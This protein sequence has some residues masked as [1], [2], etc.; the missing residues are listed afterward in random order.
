MYD[1]AD[2]L[3]DKG[4]RIYAGLAN[5]ATGSNSALISSGGDSIFVKENYA[6]FTLDK[7]GDNVATNKLTKLYEDIWYNVKVEYIISDDGASATYNIYVNDVLESTVIDATP[8]TTIAGWLMQPSRQAEETVYF[9][10]DNFYMGKVCSEHNYEDVEISGTAFKCFNENNVAVFYTKQCANCGNFGTE[11]VE[12]AGVTLGQGTYYSDATKNG[13]REDYENITVGTSFGQVLNGTNA[14]NIVNFYSIVEGAENKTL[15]L[16]ASGWSTAAVRPKDATRIAFA[17]GDKLVM[18]FDLRIDES[19]HPSFPKD[20]I[21]AKLNFANTYKTS[22]SKQVSDQIAL[23]VA[24]NGKDTIL[25]TTTLIKGV[26]Y[27]VRFELTVGGDL[28]IYV[29]GELSQTMTGYSY[30]WTEMAWYGLG[31]VTRGTLNMTID[32]MYMANLNEVI[33][34]P[35]VTE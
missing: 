20:K 24:E 27:N 17:N 23:N 32:N 35:E 31:V 5:S 25:G 26:W 6:Y 33:E 13:R 34:T 4:S 8:A 28:L 18:E 2:N 16:N 12:Y 10:F 15:N 19:G 3:S 22:D 21:A 7:N 30:A 9:K 1:G 14:P 29:N 11:T